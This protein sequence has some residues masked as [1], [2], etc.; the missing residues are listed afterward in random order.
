MSTSSQYERIQRTGGFWT[1]IGKMMPLP[2]VM[3]Q[4]VSAAGYGPPGGRGG[5][6]SAICIFEVFQC[7]S[8]VQHIMHDVVGGKPASPVGRLDGAEEGLGDGGVGPEADY[9]CYL[10]AVVVDFRLD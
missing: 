1:S 5:I 8:K 9:G 4:N 2:G 6:L 7:S 3:E 10:L